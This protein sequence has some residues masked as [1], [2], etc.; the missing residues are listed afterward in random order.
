MTKGL[1]YTIGAILYVLFPRDL[2]PDFLAG[3]GWIDDL[4]VLFLLCAVL[5][6]SIAAAAVGKPHRSNPATG[7]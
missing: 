1:I 5:P 4:I 2:I 6:G 7:R 3:W